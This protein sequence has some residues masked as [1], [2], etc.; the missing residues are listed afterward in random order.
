MSC[1]DDSDPGSDLHKGDGLKDDN[2]DSMGGEETAGGD[3]QKEDTGDSMGGKETAEGDGKKEDTGDSMGGEKTAEGAVYKT[4]ISRDGNDR[5]SMGGE[6]DGEIE[7]A[8]ELKKP[9]ESYQKDIKDISL[10]EVDE[11]KSDTPNGKA[12]DE[13]DTDSEN[14]IPPSDEEVRNVKRFDISL[15]YIT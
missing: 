15:I 5:Q 8:D 7:D 2:G 6:C 14:E 3:G 13:T 9:G 11:D 1:N 10:K 12:K 4:G